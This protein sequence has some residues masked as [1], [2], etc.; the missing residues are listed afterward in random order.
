[1]LCGVPCTNGEMYG[2][3]GHY[4]G[5]VRLVHALWSSMYKWRDVWGGGGGIFQDPNCV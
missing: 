4:E 3:G 1:M 2:G 5:L